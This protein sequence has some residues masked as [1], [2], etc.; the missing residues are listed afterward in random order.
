MM[1]VRI[2]V[3]FVLTAGLA[4][5]A[6]TP[7]SNDNKSAEPSHKM[8]GDVTVKSTDGKYTLQTLCLDTNGRVLA[9]VAPSKPFGAPVK[10]ATGEVR[11][12]D[13][14]GKPVL[15]IKVPFHAQSLNCAPD[16]TILVAGDGK[17]ARFDKDGKM[18]G[19]PADLPHIGAL[20]ADKAELRKQAEAQLKRE[21]QQFTEAIANAKK[22][23]EEQVKQL[24]KK[25]AEDRTK[26]EQRQLEQYKSLI[27]N[28]DQ[29]AKEQK[30]RTVEQV[31]ADMTGRVRVISAVAA[32]EQDL[33][34]VC[35][36]IGYGYAV[37]RMTHDLK[38]PKR[39][40]GEIRGCCG[41]MDVQLH[42]KNLLVAENCNHQFALYDR[43][44]KKLG[45]YGTRQDDNLSRPAPDGKPA[46][47]AEEKGCF[48]GCCNPMN[49]RAL[50][51]GDIFT[52]ESEG[53]VKRF[54][55]DGKFVGTAAQVKL[56]G[57]CKNVAI[58]VSAD[59]NKLYFCDQPGSKFHIFEKK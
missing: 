38:D 21:Q 20:L 49:V 55:A 9:L 28:Y 4:A 3:V 16:G 31:L 39:V 48:G 7:A 22:Q 24:E 11:V 40:L 25:K 43:D 10:G 37:W 13:P 2:G 12:F 29:M 26:T 36:D 54:T 35:G 53:I 34:V 56:T 45:G 27:Q 47:K 18:K 58:A 23:F 46:E 50:G 32:S 6:D 51:T 41:Q 15:D 57:G 30:T 17:I 42:G 14:V 59:G 8:A 19:E 33:F 5:A 1:L 52:A 44:G